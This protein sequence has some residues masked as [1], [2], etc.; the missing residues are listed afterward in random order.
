M[1]T[2]QDGSV[3]RPPAKAARWCARSLAALGVV[4]IGLMLASLHWQ[5]LDRF[6]GSMSDGLTGVDFFQMPRGFENLVC[7]RSLFLTELGRFGPHST[8]YMAHPAAAIAVGSWTFALGPWVGYYTFVGLSLALLLLAGRL[9]ASVLEGPGWKAFAYF[10]MFGG[11][12]VYYLLWAG[13]LHVVL[14]LAV[15]LILTALM[16]MEGGKGDGHFLPEWPFGGHRRDAALAQRVPVAFDPDA[17]SDR[18]YVR[19]IQAGILLSLLSKPIVRYFH[20]SRA[21]ADCAR[22]AAAFCRRCSFTR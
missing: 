19:W 4:W 20:V 22:P 6:S 7:G 16:R 3:T 11:I 13:Q 8:P 5:F 12:P 9:L 17:A 10:A 1:R 15:A 2:V 14:V 18:R 21:P